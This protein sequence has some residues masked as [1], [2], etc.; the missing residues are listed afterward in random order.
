MTGRADSEG[1]ISRNSVAVEALHPKAAANL[2]IALMT[3]PTPDP[4]CAPILA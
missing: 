4:W 1:T 3:G 2:Q